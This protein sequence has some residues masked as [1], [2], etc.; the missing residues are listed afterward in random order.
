MLSSWCLAENLALEDSVTACFEERLSHI[1]RSC[2]RWSDCLASEFYQ[3]V[4]TSR[5]ADSAIEVNRQKKE[6]NIFRKATNI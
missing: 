4:H 2:I 3:E 1:H 5:I 6:V